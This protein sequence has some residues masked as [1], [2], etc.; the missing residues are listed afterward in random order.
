VG[1]EAPGGIV[2]LGEA[3]Q[4]AAGR[5]ASAGTRRYE[6]NVIEI[7]RDNLDRL[8]RSEQELRQCFT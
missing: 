8:W 1:P 3:A 5:A 7:L 4:L 2:E 6:N